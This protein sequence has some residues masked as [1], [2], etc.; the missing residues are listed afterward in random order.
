MWGEG[1]TFQVVGM[2]DEILVF[3]VVEM[4]KVCRIR[5]P[6]VLVDGAKTTS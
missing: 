5:H 2:F 6:V 3:T 4:A 1:R